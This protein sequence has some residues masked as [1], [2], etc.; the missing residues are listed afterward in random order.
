ARRT[1]IKKNPCSVHCR[2]FLKS[3][4]LAVVSGHK[5]QAAASQ[6]ASSSRA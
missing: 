4:R 3:K 1:L 6:D 2:G 5:P